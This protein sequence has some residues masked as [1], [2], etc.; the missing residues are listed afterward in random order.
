MEKHIGDAID[1]SGIPLLVRNKRKKGSKKF[2]SDDVA[3]E[4]EPIL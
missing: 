1:N 2:K 4:N 3:V